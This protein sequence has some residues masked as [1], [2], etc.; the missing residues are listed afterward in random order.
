MQRH[1]PDVLALV[2]GLNALVALML[3]LAWHNNHESLDFA[4]VLVPLTLMSSGLIGLGFS[5]RKAAP[6]PG[7]AAS[8]APAATIGE[9]AA[10]N[11][12]EDA[13]G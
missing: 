3:W 2:F 10:S 11:P 12:G 9:S 6:T 7:S 4:P 1:K 13:L 8:E 5:L